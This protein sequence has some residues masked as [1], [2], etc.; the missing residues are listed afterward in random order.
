MVLKHLLGVAKKP[1]APPVHIAPMADELRANRENTVL[2][3]HLFKPRVLGVAFVQLQTKRPLVFQGNRVLK[4]LNTQ[5]NVPPTPPVTS[6][7]L[8]NLF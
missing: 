3:V 6:R 2:K 4:D 8:Q 5:I 1:F 7:G